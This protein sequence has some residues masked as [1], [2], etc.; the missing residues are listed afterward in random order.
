MIVGLEGDVDFKVTEAIVPCLGQCHCHLV[1]TVEAQLILMDITMVSLYRALFPYMI[2]SAKLSCN[3]LVVL[4]V[5]YN[6]IQATIVSGGS[7][8]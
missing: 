3:R 8:P 5:F 1:V 6:V 2:N 4:T 7:R